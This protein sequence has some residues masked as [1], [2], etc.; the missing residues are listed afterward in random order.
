M[1]ARILLCLVASILIGP[2][3]I[4]YVEA[5]GLVTAKDCTADNL[6]FN[7]E[8]YRE[9][10]AGINDAARFYVE[11]NPNYKTADLAQYMVNVYLNQPVELAH[12]LRDLGINP[13]SVAQLSSLAYGALVYDKANLLGYSHNFL[14][15]IPPPDDWHKGLVTP[16]SPLGRP[17]QDDNPT[18]VNGP[19][20]MALSQGHAMGE[21]IQTFYRSDSGPRSMPAE[22]VVVTAF[23]VA[24]A[25]IVTVVVMRKGKANLLVPS[26]I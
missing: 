24:V 19:R 3:A 10:I 6:T 15:E 25:G 11:D 26:R 9:D 4:E 8:L 17:L 2:V 1:I 14:R 23:L 22:Y 5:H 20:G 12:C 7:R 18:P 16:I 13:A 21:Q